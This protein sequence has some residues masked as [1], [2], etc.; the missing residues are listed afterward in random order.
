MSANYNWQAVHP[1][2]GVPIAVVQATEQPVIRC[3]VRQKHNLPSRSWA[4][5][6]ST[7]TN[8]NYFLWSLCAG[9]AG[10]RSDEE[11]TSTF[12]TH[13]R[14]T[15][16]EIQARVQ[17]IDGPYR[18]GIPIPMPPVRKAVVIHHPES[19]PAQTFTVR[20]EPRPF[21]IVPQVTRMSRH[22][23][24]G[25]LRF[26]T[27]RQS[28]VPDQF[29]VVLDMLPPAPAPPTGTRIRSVAGKSVSQG[30]SKDDV[31]DT[32]YQIGN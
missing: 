26:V 22:A 1:I 18:F 6:I 32:Y 5:C 21:H 14:K 31:V 17:E 27:E 28:C 12:E 8:T 2:H 4:V 15:W 30:D 9:L 20:P 7:W 29:D 19:G 16:D 11:W 13:Y 25:L 3:D 23:V 24:W 10:Y